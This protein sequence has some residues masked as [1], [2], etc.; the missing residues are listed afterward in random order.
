MMNSAKVGLVLVIWN[1]GSIYYIL[2]TA[3]GEYTVTAKSKKCAKEKNAKQ[4]SV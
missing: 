2:C 1:E 3:V 4:E